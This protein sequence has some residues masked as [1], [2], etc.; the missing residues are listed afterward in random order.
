[1]M[2]PATRQQ[3]LFLFFS[4]CMVSACQ[5]S[6][7]VVQVEYN[8]TIVLEEAPWRSANAEVADLDGDG[9][10]DIVL[11]IGRH[12]PGPNLLFRG[13]GAGGFTSVDS[14]SNPQDRSYSLSV[15]DMDSDG[16]FDLVVSN[17]RPDPKYVLLNDG[18]G[19]FTE[20]V[21]FGDPAWPTRN[22]TVADLNL[23]GKPD[24]VV[25]NRD[26]TPEGNNFI[27]L[28]DTQETF[29]LSCTSITSGPATTISVADINGD[30][31]PDLVVP[32]RDV[33][34]SHVYLG[35]GAGNFDKSVPF[36]PAD[37]SFRSAVALDLNRDDMLD[38]V[39]IDDR[40]KR[41]F[42]FTQIAGLKFEMGEQIDAGL[43]RPYALDLADLNGDG[44]QDLL[45]GYRN[46]P[47]RLF[48]N[49]GDTLHSVS[50][51]DSLGTVYG[52]GVGD[53][54]HDGIPDV[55]SARSDASDLLFMGS[56]S[57]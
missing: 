5:P 28:N 39:A 38:L 52:F 44:W 14:L 31:N 7:E 17:D 57:N 37:A 42:S 49:A 15:A 19:Q 45:V 48:F 54:N 16:D 3:M 35:D 55:V 21:E 30:G 2:F 6:P 50:I 33:G 36:G 29:S 40:K 27:C 20:R 53:V 56:H 9:K 32:Y 34:Q 26:N 4:A 12:W 1:M 24:I 13:D 18:S 46:A 47:A 11:A 22:S 43:D 23:D 51:G 25:A 8:N 10:N 41:T